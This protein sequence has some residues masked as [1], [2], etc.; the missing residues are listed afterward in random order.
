VLTKNGQTHLRAEWASATDAQKAALGEQLAALDTNT[1]G[2]LEDYLVRARQLLGDSAAEVNPFAGYS[3][4][5]APGAIYDFGGPKWIADEAAGVELLS[6]RKVGF[7]LVAGG[8]GERLGYPG[9]KVAL[10][11]ETVSMR[12]Y[13]Q[14]AIEHFVAFSAGHAKGACPFAIMTS[15]DTHA[16]TLTLL[17]ENDYFGASAETVTLMEQK[18]VPALLNNDAHM[19]FTAPGSFVLQTKPHGHGDVHT[20]MLQSGLAQKWLAEGVEYAFFFQDT[21][22]QALASTPVLVGNC[23]TNDLWFT[24]SA[25]SRRAGEACGAVMTLQPSAEAAAAGK[26]P[27]TCNVEYNQINALFEDAGLGGDVNIN[28][29]TGE[30]DDGING[31]SPYPGNTNQLVAHLET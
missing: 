18:K 2:G 12:S 1:P 27:M 20:L 10:P 8:L 21:Q 28:P 24:M 25:I 30:V 7:V 16:R 9:I 6:E 17:E 29:A 19:V 3:P 14:N 15:A 22:G 26:L 4:A 23:K 5:I 13:L 11:M 31:I